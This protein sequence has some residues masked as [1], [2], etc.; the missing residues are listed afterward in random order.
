MIARTSVC[1][2]AF[3]LCGVRVCVCIDWLV[4]VCVVVCV[5]MW[6][7]VHA[8]LCGV[9]ACEAGAVVFNG[10]VMSVIV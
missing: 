7:S 5:C 9:E 8:L 10:C 3:M 1:G 4:Y 2:V 6:R